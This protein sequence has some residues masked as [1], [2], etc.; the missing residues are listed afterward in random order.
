M[1]PASTQPYSSEVPR[2]GQ[3][4][5]VKPTWPYSSRNS[6]RSSA[7]RRT[8]FGLSDLI[9]LE[10]LIGSQYLR[11][12]SPADVPGPTRVIMSFSLWS[13]VSSYRQIQRTRSQRLIRVR[14]RS[15]CVFECAI[16]SHEQELLFHHMH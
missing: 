8:I 16:A 13:I 1:P 4:G 3:V 10:K 15:Y 7:S 6:R 9:S 12:V 2:C 5:S 11:N 14:A